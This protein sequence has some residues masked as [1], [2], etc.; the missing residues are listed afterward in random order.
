MGSS[1]KKKK[2]KQK[3]FQKPKLKV[4]K[5]RPKADNFTDTSFKARS[6]VVTQQSLQTAAP[7][8]ASQ[9]NHQLSLLTHKSDTQ[10]RESLAYLTGAINTARAQNAPL[11]QPVS[12]IIP[13]TLALIYDSSKAVREQLLKLFHALPPADVLPHVEELLRRTRAG[14]T[15]M[16][17]DIRI[18]SLEVLDWLLQIHPD[19]TVSCAGGWIHTLKCFMSLLGWKDAWATTAQERWSTASMSGNSSGHGANADKS[20]KL[21]IHQM[22]TLAAFLKA[23][24]VLDEEAVAAAKAEQAAAARRWFP[25]HQTRFH[26]VGGQGPNG[27]AHLNLFGAPRDEDADMYRDRQGR[28]RAFERLIQPATEA[29]L[30]GA[31]K[32]GGTLG[33]A[34]AEVEKVIL[35]GMDD[36]FASSGPAQLASELGA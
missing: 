26:M 4:G 1:S 16:A 3:D 36:Y 18:N 24:L 5:T 23:G 32:E 2:E 19:E 10:R 6:I 35:D 27:F 28:Q 20:K 30:P 13:R 14:L 25:L 9:F 22:K 7:S 21:R 34:A 17:L 11:P 15:S 33:R 8:V 12:I 31:K 29:G